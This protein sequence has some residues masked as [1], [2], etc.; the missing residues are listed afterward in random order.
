MVNP[1]PEGSLVKLNTGDIAVVRK[2]VR[3]M[4][5]RPLISIINN[6]GPKL[7]MKDVDLY[8]KRN[9]VIIEPYY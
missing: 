9:M 3:D 6:V 8:E 2:V 5:L 7:V 1:Y 4:P